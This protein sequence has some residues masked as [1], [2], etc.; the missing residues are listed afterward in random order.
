[1]VF[2]AKSSTGKKNHRNKKS[3]ENCLED[4]T[5]CETIGKI[6]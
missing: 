4:M 5:K 2:Q 1:M 6:G 3:V